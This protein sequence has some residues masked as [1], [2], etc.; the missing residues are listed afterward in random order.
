MLKKFGYLTPQVFSCE[1]YQV[2]LYFHLHLGPLTPSGFNITGEYHAIMDVM[3]TFE[4]NPPGGSGQ[5]ALVDYYRI[6]IS[7]TQLFP[8]SNVATSLSWNAT[9]EYNTVYTATI[10]AI[11]C[12]GESEAYLLPFNIEFGKISFIHVIV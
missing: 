7:P 5:E 11:N 1:Q 9:L 2:L 4:W 8:S 6:A 3:V 12:A 10:T